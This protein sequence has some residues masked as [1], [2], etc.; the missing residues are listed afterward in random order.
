M[1]TPT[2]GKVTRADIEQKLRNLQGDVE[3]KVVSQRQKIIAGAAAFGALVI[4]ITFLLG[5]RSGKKK[6]T[7]V[8]IRRF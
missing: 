7:V 5:R 3:R 8:E 4:I 1:S 6:N 2:T